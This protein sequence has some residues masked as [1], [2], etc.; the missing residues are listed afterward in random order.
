M[1]AHPER[2][3][4]TQDLDGVVVDLNAGVWTVRLDDPPLNPFGDR[5]ISALCAATRLIS[6]DDRSRAVVLWGGPK[7][8]AVGAD[9][10]ALAA[11]HYDSIV[12]WNARLQA[13]FSA[14]ADL[15]LPVI[16]AVTGYALGGGLELALCAD[17]RI[18]TADTTLGL[19]EIT[20]G[21]IPGAGGTQRLT[22]IVGHSR[23]MEMIMTA[24]RVSAEQALTLGVLDEIVDD[25]DPLRRAVSFARDLA[26]RPHLA[27]RAAKEAIN[28]AHGPNDTG[29]A[30]ERS[31]IAGLFAT[32]DR[33]RLMRAFLDRAR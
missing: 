25:A 3:N 32:P 17:Y 10:N 22:R 11:M 26:A 15:P 33:E 27:I 28:A 9:I 14:I 6:Q 21:I 20:L 2:S 30:L 24:R 16:A 19:P 12:V 13:A 18:G 29:L 7:N 4:A 23:A 5:L 31:L 1:N 8:F